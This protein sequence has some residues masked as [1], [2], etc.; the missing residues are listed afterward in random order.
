MQIHLKK[1]AKAVRVKGR[2]SSPPQAAFLRAKT[3]EMLQPG[4]VRRNN[5]FQLACAFLLVLK[6]GPE[7]FRFTVGLRPVNNHRIPFT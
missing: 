3:D 5:Q 6:I 7:Q 4:P 2:R 1:N